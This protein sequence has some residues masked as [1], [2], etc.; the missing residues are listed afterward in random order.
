MMIADDDSTDSM[1]RTESPDLSG[2]VDLAEHGWG[3]FY[4]FDRTRKRFLPFS[5]KPIS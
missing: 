1:A 5:S 3:V 2:T 4:R